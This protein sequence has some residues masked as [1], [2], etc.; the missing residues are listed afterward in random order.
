MKISTKLTLQTYAKYLSI[1]IVS[2]S[3]MVCG[4]YLFFVFA[5]FKIVNVFGD[6]MNPTYKNGDALILHQKSVVERD[7]VTVFLPND[8]WVYGSSSQGVN[9]LVKRTK[10]IP[11]DT[12][13]FEGMGRLSI[14][15][16]DGSYA[17]VIEKPGLVGFDECVLDVK[18]S[19]TLKDNEYFLIG[20]NREESYDSFTAWC[21]GANPVVKREDVIMTGDVP[22]RLGF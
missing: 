18:E 9:I 16:A 6:S 8:T 22:L 12:V 7:D 10:G 4:L 1:S 17:E 13:A 2:V 11:G 5:P 3:L 21:R 19:Y 15:S 14:K 20:D